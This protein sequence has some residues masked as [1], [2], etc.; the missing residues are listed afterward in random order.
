M[1]TS[2]WLLLIANVIFFALIQR[3]GIWRDELGTQAQ[4]ALREENVRLVVDPKGLPGSASTATVP[5]GTAASNQFTSNLQLSLTISPPVA[6]R[7]MAPVCLEW[8]EFSGAD[9]KLASIALLALRLGNKLDKRQVEQLIGYWVYIPPLD[10][11]AA[12]SQKIEQLKTRGIEEYFIVQETGPWRNAISLGV[13]KTREAALNF[14]NVL[15]TKDV[16]TAQVGERAGRQKATIF[17]LNGVGSATEAKLKS[18]QKDFPGS[19][20]KSV[21]CAH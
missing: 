2:F 3:W 10:S 15:R 6:S 8:G 20:L 5:A 12:V 21:P 11:K 19:E 17:I 1:K 14:L 7:T 18:L 4:P 9:L 13:F 16:R